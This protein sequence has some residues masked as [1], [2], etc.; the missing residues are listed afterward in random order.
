MLK[1]LL[2][3]L[4]GL[5][6]LVVVLLHFSVRAFVKFDGKNADVKVK[7]LFFTLYPRPE[8][9]NKTT[10]ITK[11]SIASDE[12]NTQIVTDSSG[13]IQPENVNIKP[14]EGVIE[15]EI[16]SQPTEELKPPPKHKVAENKE[17]KQSL[18]DKINDNKEKWH[19][20]KPYVPTSWKS[21]KKLLKTIRFTHTDIEITTGKEDA[22][23]SAMFY[24]KVNAAL[25][26]GL[27]VLGEI[28]TMHYKSTKVNCVFNRD[29]LDFS[30]E[31]QVRVRPSAVV[32]IAF[33][34]LVNYLKIYLKQRKN[35][36]KL[37]E[38]ESAENE[39]TAKA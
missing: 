33:C 16:S 4:L 34:T 31:T 30:V 6:A 27:A 21:V 35:N 20:I 26:N 18:K 5:V 7:Y 25:Y 9:K 8:K 10:Q 19:K 28:F 2:W 15:K 1:I 24:G 39:R 3:V 14:D 29:T 13:E 38:T 22:Y 23:D 17:N 11:T 32:A 12:G 36:K 37:N